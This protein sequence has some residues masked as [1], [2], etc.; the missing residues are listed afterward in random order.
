MIDLGFGNPDIPSPQIAV[1]KLNQAAHIARNHRY[2]VSRGLCRS[3]REAA[4]AL[5]QRNWGV[6]LDPELEI[7]NTKIGSKGRFHH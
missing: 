2:S 3:C 6:Q 4:A 7:T 1:D 5:Y